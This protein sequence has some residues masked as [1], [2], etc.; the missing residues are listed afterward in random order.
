MAIPRKLCF[1]EV[2]PGVGAR[3]STPIRVFFDSAVRS[4]EIS[5][6]FSLET[7]E[8]TSRRDE[9][10]SRR[11]GGYYFEFSFTRE[12]FLVDTTLMGKIYNPSDAIIDAFSRKS[13]IQKATG[14][15]AST[16]V[17]VEGA[18][19]NAEI[20]RQIRNLATSNPRVAVVYVSG[21]TGE[22][23]VA[24]G[25]VFYY[26]VEDYL[27]EQVLSFGINIFSEFFK[28]GVLPAAPKNAPP[29]HLLAPLKNF[30]VQTFLD[31]FQAILRVYEEAI[32]LNLS[33]LNSR[34]LELE[35]KEKLVFSGR[36][37]F[38]VLEAF[39]RLLPEDDRLL[40]LPARGQIEVRNAEAF[41]S[42]RASDLTR[43]P[44]GEIKRKHFGNGL[45]SKP[46]QTSWRAYTS[47]MNFDPTIYVGSW[48]IL[49]PVQ[50]QAEGSNDLDELL[51]EERSGTNRSRLGL[52]T[53]IT[54]SWSYN[55]ITTVDINESGF[56]T[57]IDVTDPFL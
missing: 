1:L 36:S 16:G 43:S 24:T 13:I 41:A 28:G 57:D 44:T 17:T 29:T 37:F 15:L 9:A 5:A 11:A 27:N 38:D 54:H 46:I 8:R 48:L 50:T 51:N 7:P 55:P 3:D 52:V 32:T 12:P 23:D 45:I 21:G 35:I 20:R 30:T 18:S 33:G 25:R 40:F 22:I 56:F 42:L 53:K 39:N 6:D 31:R 49:S 4:P 19:D 47:T 10:S 14:I 34:I 26:V 2:T